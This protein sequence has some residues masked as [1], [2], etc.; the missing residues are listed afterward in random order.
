MN[1]EQKYFNT[2]AKELGDQ[3]SA[4]DRKLLCVRFSVDESYLSHLFSG[5]RKA[6]RGKGCEIVEFSK[7]LAAINSQKLELA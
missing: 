7:K 5:H 3:L 4:S 1:T 6:M 2:E